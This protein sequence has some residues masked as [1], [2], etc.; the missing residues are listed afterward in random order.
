MRTLLGDGDLTD[1]KPHDAVGWMLEALRLHAAGDLTSPPRLHAHLDGGDLVVTAGGTSRW[2]GFRSY[3]TL[4]TTA[5]QQLVVTHDRTSGRVEAIHVDQQLGAMRTGA[6]GGAAAALLGPTGSCTVAIVGAGRQAWWQM[7][8]LSS[9]LDIARVQVAS[10]T[11]ASRDAFAH[12]A[13]TD[14]GLTAQPAASIRD[15]VRDADLVV[16]ATNSPTPVVDVGWLR[17]DVMVTT[18]GPKQVG[19]SEFDIDLV[20]GA[21]LV[22]CDSPTQLEAYDPPALVAAAGHHHRV[23]D[24]GHIALDPEKATRTGRRVYLSVGLAGTE[25]HLLGRLSAQLAVPTGH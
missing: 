23:L 3:D 18:M 13:R 8:A 6:L 19:R 17:E 5:G 24:L 14:L 21:G 9:V 15:A 10:R 7:W 1:V 2:Y 22:T 25:V 16:L 4:R 20:T 11:P 12:R